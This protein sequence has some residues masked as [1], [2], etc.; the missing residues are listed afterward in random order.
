[1]KKIT[2]LS[3]MY[4]SIEHPTYGIFVKNQVELLK[5][6]GVDVDVIAID[7]PAKGKVSNVKKYAKWFV[8]SLFHMLKN[9]R[10]IALTHA[11]YAFPTGFI[12]MVGK[13]LFNLPY[14]VTVHGGD[15]DKMASKNARIEAMTKKILTTADAVIVVGERLKRDVIDRFEVQKD[16]VHVM[17][18][19]V[20]TSIFVPLEKEEARKEL[21]IPLE[22]KMVL[23]VGNMIEVKGIL[24]LLD[25]SAILHKVD[26]ATALY[27]IG[28]NKDQGFMERFQQKTALLEVPVIHHLPMQQRDVAKW[29]AAADV[30]VLPSHHE[31]FGLVAL[32]AM[33]I[34]TTVV[35]TDVGGLSYLLGDQTGILV[36][37]RNA[38]A[39]AKGIRQAL[40]EVNDERK[41]KMKATVSM[42]SYEVIAKRLMALYEVIGKK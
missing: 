16:K 25:A 14:V 21:G 7:D 5:S 11:H 26:P 6:K 20:D 42:H 27:L 13:K 12:S 17:S 37:P 34:G 15:I 35:G 40:E 3:N 29:I 30:F 1:M 32:E 41:S 33:A 10:E 24:E 9:K 36:E 39:L 38:E 19:G 18:M 28:S 31:G 2:V 22:Q 23:Y 4:P 8:T